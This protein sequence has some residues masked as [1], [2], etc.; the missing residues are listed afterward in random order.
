MVVV[1]TL[2]SGNLTP[3][4]MLHV[5]SHSARLAGGRGN[6]IALFVGVKLDYTP[7][8]ER[9]RSLSLSPTGNPVRVN[10]NANSSRING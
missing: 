4:R 5:R 7:L 3:V 10:S 6:A 2:E 8:L 9:L 1:A